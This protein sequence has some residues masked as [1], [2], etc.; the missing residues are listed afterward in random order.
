MFVIT[1]KC[2]KVHLEFVHLF[3]NA[4]KLV[5]DRIVTMQLSQNQAA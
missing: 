1:R 2:G 4:L 3:I 5:A